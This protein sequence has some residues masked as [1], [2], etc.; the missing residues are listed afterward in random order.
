MVKGNLS[1]VL[2]L[3]SRLREFLEDC[4]SG[5]FYLFFSPNFSLLLVW[6]ECGYEINWQREYDGRVLFSTY[7]TQCLQISKLKKGTNFIQ[8][9]KNQFLNFLMEFSRI[10]F[11]KSMTGIGLV[12][13][14]FWKILILGLLPNLRL[15]FNKA[16]SL[17]LK[18]EFYYFSFVTILDTKVVKR[19]LLKN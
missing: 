6:H 7:A 3:Q 2:S 19:S 9:W 8:C 4:S 5:T 10:L 12:S 18:F 16:V 11:W 17:E 14:P 15:S 13:N 1:I